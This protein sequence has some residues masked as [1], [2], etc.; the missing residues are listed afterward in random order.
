MIYLKMPIVIAIDGYS[1]CGKSTFAKTIAN[2]LQYLYIDSGAMYRA[3]T[4]FSLREKIIYNGNVNIDILEQKLNNVN[5]EYR[6]N[7]T[8]SKYETFL[9]EENVEEEI[10]G[11]EVSDNVS[12]VSKLK[13][14]R[15]YLVLLQQKLGDNKGIVMDGRD[16]G[17]VVFP[18][19]EIKLFMTANIE[20][21]ALRR[22]KE[23]SDKG[24]NTTFE[25]ITLNISQRDF[26]DANREESPLRQASDSILLDNSDMTPD[27]QL[28]WFKKLL[29]KFQ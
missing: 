22:Y 24:I 17:T 3:I 16:I 19:A 14:V 6:F 29:E 27:Q 5:L 4:L 1:S 12:K 10:R 15:S 28:E 20:V 23:L 9:N 7:P 11:L 21:R 8:S 26:L 13:S 25:E 18:N 2:Y